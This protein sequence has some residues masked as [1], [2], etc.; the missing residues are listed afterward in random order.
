MNSKLSNESTHCLKLPHA[1]YSP[2][3]YNIDSYSFAPLTLIPSSL[4]VSFYP[5]HLA[6][7]FTFLKVLSYSILRPLQSLLKV[8]L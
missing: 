2:E 1:R 3:A 7:H 6:S 4:D 5:V 8:R